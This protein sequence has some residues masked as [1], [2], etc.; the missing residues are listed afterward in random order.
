GVTRPRS[1]GATTRREFRSCVENSVTASRLSLRPL[2]KGAAGPRSK[3]RR[4]SGYSRAAYVGAR[5]LLRPWG[6]RVYPTR[7]YPSCGVP[8]DE[9][10]V[11]EQLCEQL[12]AVVEILG[13]RASGD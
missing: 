6:A 5:A 10:F 7:H 13:Q 11:G 1:S 2:P 3:R 8:G 4:A 12:G 9:P